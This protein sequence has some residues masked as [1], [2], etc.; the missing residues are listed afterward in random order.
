[1]RVRSDEDGFSLLEITCAVAIVALLAAI[2]L[3]IMPRRTSH[4]QLESYAVEIAA[5]LKADRNAAMRHRRDVATK[6][7]VQTRTLRSGAIDRMIHVP[8]DVSVTFVLANTCR[9]QRSESAIVF[10]AS[11]ISCGGV[12]TLTRFGSGYE[13]RVAWLTGGVEIVPQHAT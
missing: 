8:D 10:L 2:M 13:I 11:G 12:I 7:D 6:V 3:P 5:L 9:G 4:L 1:M